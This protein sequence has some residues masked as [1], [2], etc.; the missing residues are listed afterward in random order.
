MYQP[1]RLAKRA[2]QVGTRFENTQHLIVKCR[3]RGCSISNQPPRLKTNCRQRQFFLLWGAATWKERGE[4]KEEKERK[5]RKKREK[6]KKRKEEGLQVESA[7]LGRLL[8]C[9]TAR[10]N[11]AFKEDTRG[12]Y[13]C[14]KGSSYYNYLWFIKIDCCFDHFGHQR[15][16]QCARGDMMHLC[17]QAFLDLV[18]TS[19]CVRVST[20]YINNMHPQRSKI[21][22]DFAHLLTVYE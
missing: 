3:S 7:K 9:R 16:A 5:R 19:S 4:K 1:R 10:A 21:N 2:C 17:C 22:R 20:F 15:V 18:A 13:A 6:E 12:R 11:D 8:S 14:N